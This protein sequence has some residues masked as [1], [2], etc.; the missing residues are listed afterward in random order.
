M[1]AITKK[2]LDRL[3]DRL[4]EQGVDLQVSPQALS[5]LARQGKDSRYGA[6]PLRRLIRNRVEDPAAELLLQGD[7]PEGS[8]LE[9][10]E[11]RGE[12]TIRARQMMPRV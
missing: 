11:C 3:G 8:V 6:R 12:L 7:L 2:L 5:W 9:V 4:A 1:T 10:A